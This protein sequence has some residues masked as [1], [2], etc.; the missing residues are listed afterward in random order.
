M[1]EVGFPS[2]LFVFLSLAH[3][4]VGVLRLDVRRRDVVV[5]LQPHLARPRVVEVREG[6][7]VLGADGRAQDD[8]RDSSGSERGSGSEA[9]EEGEGARTLEMSLNSFQ[10]SSSRSASRK[11]GSNLGPP[12]MAMLSAL[13]V[14][15]DGRSARGRGGSQGGE[16]SK[17][18]GGEKGRRR[19]WAH[20]RGGSSCGRR[21][22]TAAG[23]R[24]GASW[25]WRRRAAASAGNSGR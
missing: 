16:E 11:S 23:W 24:G 22:Q 10:S 14:R 2:R 12:G 18:E 9:R 19:R 13:D 1:G 8:L 17:E 4:Q 21:C 20:R 6:D 3:G 5:V 7:A 25:T 15:K